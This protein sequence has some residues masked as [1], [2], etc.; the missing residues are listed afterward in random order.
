MAVKPMEQSKKIILTNTEQEFFMLVGGL[1]ELAET[2]KES[3][4][5]SRINLPMII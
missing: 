3:G 4:I 1:L 5:Y 2:Q